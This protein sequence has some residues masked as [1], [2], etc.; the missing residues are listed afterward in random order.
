M[1][2]R[3]IQRV[4]ATVLL[5]LLL[6]ATVRAES[7]VFLDAPEARQKLFKDLV[8]A[9]MQ[10]IDAAFGGF[11]AIADFRIRIASPKENFAP[12]TYLASYDAA[13]NT[14]TFD[15]RVLSALD[16]R[17]LM[18]AEKYWTFYEQE[19]L[20][21]EFW[22]IGVVDSALWTAFMSQVAQQ[23]EMTWPHEGCSST[24]MRERLG[25][26][27]L[28]SGIGSHLRSR[29]RRIYNTNRLDRLWPDTLTDLEQTGWREGARRYEEV[30]DLGGMELLQPLIKQFGA[31]RVFA[32][33]AQTP[34]SIEDDNVR[35]SALQY[36]ERA[37]SALAW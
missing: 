26:E 37:R 7:N 8:E 3:R 6:T 28:V 5:G 29:Y 33:V 30:R 21:E 15:R 10:A 22:I 16:N 19:P 1:F 12:T 27:M 4:L 13:P 9:R 36:Q 25:C 23:H 34:F 20:R 14:L 35:V 31:P 18:V 24:R 2:L 11:T 32:Y 17:L